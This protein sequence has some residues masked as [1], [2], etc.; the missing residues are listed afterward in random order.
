MLSLDAVVL[1][2]IKLQICVFRK[3]WHSH[4]MSSLTFHTDVLIVCT[5]APP[6][7]EKIPIFFREGDVCTKANVLRHL[8]CKGSQMNMR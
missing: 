8:N 5:D 3:S 1:S 7:S 2:N 4:Y 6:R